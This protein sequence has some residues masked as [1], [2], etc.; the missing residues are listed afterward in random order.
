[1][2]KSAYN[3]AISKI[4]PSDE[5]KNA[6]LAK[7]QV[8]QNAAYDNNLHIVDFTN[9]NKNKSDKMFTKRSKKMLIT[10][11]V[12]TI[13]V[14]PAML[15]VLFTSRF[16]YMGSNSAQAPEAAYE[17]TPETTYDAAPAAEEAMPY[18]E[19]V[20]QIPESDDVHYESETDMGSVTT[21][22]GFVNENSG[23]AY[24]AYDEIIYGTAIEITD[25]HI[26]ILTEDSEQ[27]ECIITNQT[28]LNTQINLQNQNISVSVI[29]NTDGSYNA[30]EINLM[31]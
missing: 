10:A 8:T 29:T 31:D 11:A 6:T 13:I 5:W 7:M 25:T 23:G 19:P 9:A 20:A 18:D 21:G 4:T 30:I 17:S 24:I 22:E 1:M 28:V 3:S 15:A 2:N 27:I 26:V 14:M 12:I 16:N